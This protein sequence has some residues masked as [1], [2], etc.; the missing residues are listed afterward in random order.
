M[1]QPQMEDQRYHSRG[2][3][4]SPSRYPAQQQQQPPHAGQPQHGGYH[5]G[6]GGGAG[7]Y[8]Q[9][10]SQQQGHAAR[11]KVPAAGYSGGGGGGYGQ[12][13]SA[14]STGQLRSG[15][16]EV[17]TLYGAQGGGQLSV[18]SM[19]APNNSTMQCGCE[20]IDCPF[21]NLMLSVQMKDA[22]SY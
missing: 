12:A 16:I 6:A 10:Q 11:H 2:S 9:Q 14:P 15:H 20:N 8:H 22:G 17:D 18:N 21:C 3:H 7:Y 5:S 19:N 4:K 1:T 13:P